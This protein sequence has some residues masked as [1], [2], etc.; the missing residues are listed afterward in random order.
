M[1]SNAS[2][3]VNL[4]KITD[5]MVKNKFTYGYKKDADSWA[6]AK[7]YKKETCA[8]M[9]SQALQETGVLKPK[10]MIWSTED[11]NVGY[12]AHG[13]NKVS[14]VKKRL[15]KYMYIKRVKKLFKKCKDD[16]IPGDV[17]VW[18]HHI[19][20]FAG[21]DKN[22]NAVFYDSGRNA[23]YSVKVGSQFK[24]CH[25]VRNMDN[26]KVYYI[27]RFRKKYRTLK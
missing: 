14:E 23:T 22:G 6:S 16:L 18:K 21:F 1:V 11:G 4:R 13:K 27:I 20:V 17:I 2:F 9:V 12:I 26:V 3:L 15:K 10:T 5:Y 7:K 8:T 24:K 25:K 19:S